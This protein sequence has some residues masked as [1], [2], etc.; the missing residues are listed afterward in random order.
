MLFSLYAIYVRQSGSEETFDEFLYWGDMLL[1]DFDDIDKYIVNS[2]QLFSNLSDLKALDINLVTIDA[3]EKFLKALKDIEEPEEKRK[4]IG[5][6]FVDTFK[7]ESKKLGKFD[8]LA[9]GTLYTDVIESGTKTAKT[10]KSHHNVGGLP[11]ELGFK[12][13]EPLRTLFK[14]EVRNLGLK[15]GLPSS[16]I[17]RQPFPGPGLAIRIIGNVTKEKIKI[18]QDSDAILQEEIKNANLDKEIWQYFTVLSNVKS[19]GVKGD[20]RSYEYMLGIRAV[21]SIDGMTA[22]F[23]HIP[24]DVLTKISSRIVNEVKGVNRVTYDITQKPPS[25]IEW[26]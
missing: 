5:K 22:N 24:Y 25:T 10:I 4:I 8:Y 13:I 7:E 9:Q 6:L 19:V 2:E 11:K 1:N 15:L 12:L 18:V 26:E 3:S 16:L 14:D 21:T 20:E 17:H 23:A